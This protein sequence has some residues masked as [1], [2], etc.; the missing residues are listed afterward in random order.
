MWVLQLLAWVALFSWLSIIG[1]AVVR[2]LFGKLEPSSYFVARLL[3]LVVFFGLFWLVGYA[4]VL[5]LSTTS[6]L[7]GL[8]VAASGSL[9][10]L[11]KSRTSVHWRLWAMSE[12]VFLALLLIFVAWRG[13]YPTVTD[14]E[15]PM[16]IMM[17]SSVMQAT[18]LPPEDAWL[19]G[20]PLNYYY[21]GYFVFG[22]LGKMLNTSSFIAVGF[23]LA[24]IWAL[25]L[26][27]LGYLGWILTRKLA[28]AF[29]VPI[30]Y[31]IFSN[32]AGFF[33]LITHW[34]EPYNWWKPSRALPDTIT[35]FPAFSYLFADFHPHMIASV[36]LIT[37]IIAVYLI[38][39]ASRKTLWHGLLVGL[40]FGELFVV[41]SWSVLSAGIFLIASLIL[42]RPSW[43]VVGVALLTS[44]VIVWPY[45]QHTT[46][47]WEGFGLVTERSALGLWLSHW[48][49]ILAGLLGFI[50][51]PKK[52]PLAWAIVGTGVLLVALA[53]VI[54]VRDAIG[55]RFNTLF[56]LYWDAW[57][58][59]S[60]AAGCGLA[61]FWSQRAWG[62]ATVVLISAVA[63]CYVV[64]AYPE[65]FN[66]FERWYGGD[67]ASLT[68]SQRP[69]LL[70]PYLELRQAGSNNRLYE[71]WGSAYSD[72]SLL[73]AFTGLPT[74]LGWDGH[75][76]LWRNSWEE[77]GRRKDLANQITD[78]QIPASIQE[79]FHFTYCY[80]GDGI[81]QKIN[82]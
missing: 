47:I 19:A 74:L 18:S 79:E 54:V 37:L 4:H 50:L 30:A 34:G 72:D 32:L 9:F 45:Q 5:P 75:E 23:G 14:G 36:W 25:S 58:Y 48:G 57:L 65:R 56:K 39:Q 33:Q 2:A 73:S 15:K 78:C 24:S 35:E 26:I 17:V 16:E 63:C 77:V 53:E 43:K 46:S 11:L 12:L 71:K 80:N 81:I 13:F 38:S 22:T 66:N 49:I 27:G 55:G 29:L 1:L 3:G 42:I 20:Q 28:G 44:A 59:L 67:P 69:E 51:W 6:L 70:Q 64:F 7:I 82:D 52:P 40:I 60:I 68:F 31:A 41:S 62:R 10:Y 61:W 21:F 8:A 76:A